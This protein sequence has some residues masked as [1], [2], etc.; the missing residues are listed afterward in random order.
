MTVYL[1]VLALCPTPPHCTSSRGECAALLPPGSG[2]A[3]LP[4]R[5]PGS[6][7]A[8]ANCAEAFELA[9]PMR[10]CQPSRD[11]FVPRDDGLLSC[12]GSLPNL[13]SLHVIAR[14]VRCA[15]APRQRGGALAEAISR[16]VAM[17]WRSLRGCANLLEIA[18]CLAMTGYLVVLALC[19]IPPLCTSSRGQCVAVLPLG[20][21]AAHLPKRSPR[22]WRCIGQLCRSLRTGAPYEA[23][24]T[25]TRSLR[26]SR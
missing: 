11:R 9:L 25:R 24:P 23:V 22:Q 4:K 17:R 10:L 21:G 12:A 7:D 18:S 26:A 15:A 14:R 19:P 20:S 16:V 8:L 6:G 5:S 3:H 13:A 2:A 1:V